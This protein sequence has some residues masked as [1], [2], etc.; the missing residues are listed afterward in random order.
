MSG[1]Q[2]DDDGGT[3]TNVA[4]SANLDGIEEEL[5]GLK[6]QLTL[7][8]TYINGSKDYGPFSKGVKFNTGALLYFGKAISSAENYL[9]GT[10]DD[11]RI[12]D[13][14][15]SDAEVKALYDLGQ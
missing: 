6:L 1:S 11:L 13:R 2:F 5:A 15:L 7:I 10:L 14:T 9:D 8:N 4:A 3:T 12:Y